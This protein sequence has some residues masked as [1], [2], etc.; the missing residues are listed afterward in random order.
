MNY[1]LSKTLGIL[2]LTSIL[3]Y[4]SIYGQNKIKGK[5]NKYPVVVN[6]E[7]QVIPEFEDSEKWIRHDLWVE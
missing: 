3:F 2:V 7:T 4:G 6:G 5:Q 1:S